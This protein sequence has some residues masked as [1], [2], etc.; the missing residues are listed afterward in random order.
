MRRVSGGGVCMTGRSAAPFG[1]SAGSAPGDAGESNASDRG[2]SAPSSN[3]NLKKVGLS[4]FVL[5]VG[6]L[7][8]DRLVGVEKASAGDSSMSAPSSSSLMPSSGD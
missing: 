8:R 7:G 1:S 5:P 3:S 2:M 4:G 6:P